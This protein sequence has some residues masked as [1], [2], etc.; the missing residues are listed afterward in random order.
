MTGTEWAEAER[1][2]DVKAAV[3]GR[4]KVAR[5]PYAAGIMDALTDSEHTDVAFMKPVQCGGTTIGENGLGAWIYTDPGPVM[6]VFSGE[7][8]TKKRMREDIIPLVK[9]TPCLRAQLTGRSHDLKTSVV[10]LRS[11]VIHTGWAGSAASLASVPIRYLILDEVDKYPR[12]VGKEADPMSLGKM[13]TRTF[14]HRKKIYTLSTPTLPTGPIARAVESCGDVRDWCPKC[15]HCSKY[16]RPD[17]ERVSWEGMDTT[18]EQEMR[19]I[20][21]MLETME[22]QAFYSC[23]HCEEPITSEDFWEASKQGGWVTVGEELPDVHPRSRSVGFR[24]SG[25]CT[26][27]TRVQGAAVEFVAARLGGME[28][29]QNF[30]NSILGVPFWGEDGAS[31]DMTLSVTPQ[32]VWDLTKDAGERGVVPDW[33]TCIVA[34]VDSGKKDHPFVVRA[35]GGDFKSQLIEYGVA[36]DGEAV[37]ALLA[38]PWHG[39]GGREYFIRRMLIDSGGG[40]GAKNMTRTEEV[41]RLAQRD[42][43]RIWAIKGHGGDNA[44]SNPIVTKMHHYRPPGDRYL[45]TLDV[46]LSLLDVGYWKDLTASYIN[47]GLW[48]PHTSVGRGYVMQLAS[49]HK[50]MVRQIIKPDGTSVEDWRWVLRATGLP[51]HWWDAE[52]YATA[53]AHML[54]ADSMVDEP[55]VD[56]DEFPEDNGW[57]GP[58][59]FT[60]NGSWL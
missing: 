9:G 16:I 43:A 55:K 60:R 11:C 28:K 13:R 37:L 45:N 54:G 57:Q 29:I 44:L 22:V 21:V 47:T 3:P 19:K 38:R 4:Y 6:I 40:R 46:R 15:P 34:G 58:S 23:P 27:W 41:Y 30:F 8:V 36:P 17:W 50:I 14:K 20:R 10:K 31:G 1:V 12:W 42:P 26:D 5:T 53:A 33:A 35:F 59:S 7:E 2:L 48:L 52:V 18:D 49:E 39:T 32:K 24:L 51:N 56:Y 25:L